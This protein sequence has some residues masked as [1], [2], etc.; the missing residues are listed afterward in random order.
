MITLWNIM[1]DG[2]I[3][4]Y[5]TEVEDTE[6]STEVYSAKSVLKNKVDELVNGYNKCPKMRARMRQDIDNQIEID[7][8]VDYAGYD[9]NRGVF[10][11]SSGVSDETSDSMTF[12]IVNTTSLGILRA[13]VDIIIQLKNDLLMDVTVHD[14]PALLC[15]SVDKAEDGLLYIKFKK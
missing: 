1:E 8:G 13:Y 6:D 5:D 3:D 11:I 15:I 14:L 4:Y 7:P 10:L 2:I 9:Q 12:N